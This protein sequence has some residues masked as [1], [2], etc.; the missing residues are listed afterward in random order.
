MELRREFVDRTFV[1][2]ATVYGCAIEIPH[3]ISQHSVVA[4]GTVRR[5][6]ESMDYTLSPASIV[7]R[8]LEDRAATA[9]VGPA[10]AGDA[11]QIAGRV[12]DEIANGAAAVVSAREVVEDCFLPT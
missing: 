5:A 9:S 3:C 7:K 4:E 2:D 8:Q 11:E 12:H 6:V 10:F 1:V